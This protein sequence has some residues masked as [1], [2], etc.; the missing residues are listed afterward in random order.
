MTGTV[1]VNGCVRDSSFLQQSAYVPQ[2]SRG[3]QDAG[4]SLPQWSLSISCS[5]TGWIPCIAASLPLFSH[6]DECSMHVTCIHAAMASRWVEHSNRPPCTG[7]P[8][9]CRASTSCQAQYV[10]GIDAAA[11]SVQKRCE[12]GLDCQSGLAASAGLGQRYL[13]C[14]H[15]HQGVLFQEF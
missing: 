8:E 9:R 15:I 5:G 2:V 1:L 14:I 13:I 12:R 6:V 11:R 10:E 3:A 4:F 7:V